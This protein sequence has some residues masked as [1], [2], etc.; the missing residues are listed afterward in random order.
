MMNGEIFLPGRTHKI[1]EHEHGTLQTAN[2]GHGYH[3]LVWLFARADQLKLIVELPEP[4]RLVQIAQARGAVESL[5]DVRID[6]RSIFLKPEIPIQLLTETLAAG[7]MKTRRGRA[8][9]IDL[10]IKRDGLLIMTMG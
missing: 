6:G 2:L 7:R 4:L 5:K 9:Q 1:E 10:D 3:S 8:W